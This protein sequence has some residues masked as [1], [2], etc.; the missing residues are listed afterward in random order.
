MSH[1]SGMVRFP[2]GSIMHY[3]YD[4]TSD[5]CI[6]KLYDT[7]AEM[8]EHWRKY[9]FEEETGCQHEEEIVEIYTSYGGGS[10]WEGTACR[11]CNMILDNLDPYNLPDGVG[12]V[13]EEPMWANPDLI[14]VEFEVIEEPVLQIEGVKLLESSK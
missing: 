7:N 5:Y 2:D 4:G 10:H 12:Y 11:K 8:C 6:P 14:E 13:D 1:A 3:E 9:D